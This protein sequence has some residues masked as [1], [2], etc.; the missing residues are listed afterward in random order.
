LLLSYTSLL[1]SNLSV[2]IE[3]FEEIIF[4]VG[5]LSEFLFIP[6]YSHSK[7]EE[8]QLFHHSLSILFLWCQNCTLWYHV[9]F[10]SKSD[11][12]SFKSCL[13]AFEYIKS[14]LGWN[15]IESIGS[16]DLDESWSKFVTRH[17]EFAVLRRYYVTV[18]NTIPLDATAA[19]HD[20]N[21]LIS[22]DTP[23]VSELFIFGN[24]NA[25]KHKE[26]RTRHL[27]IKNLRHLIK[28]TDLVLEWI[29]SD[30]QARSGFSNDD[31]F[32]IA[33]CKVSYFCLLADMK[34]T[35]EVE[36]QRQ[37]KVDSTIHHA[38]SQFRKVYEFVSHVCD[39]PDLEL[40]PWF[41][42]F[43]DRWLEDQKTEFCESRVQ[44][45]VEL[46]QDEPTGKCTTSVVDIFKLLY[47]MRNIFTLAAYSEAQALKFA[48]V[49]SQIIIFY[50]SKLMEDIRK[51]LPTRSRKASQEDAFTDAP[52]AEI[53]AYL[54]SQ[55]VPRLLSYLNN[56]VK[57]H[58]LL[59]KMLA[60][61]D[62]PSVYHSKPVLRDQVV[63]EADTTVSEVAPV[64]ILSDSDE[65]ESKILDQLNCVPCLLHIETSVQE[66][67][68][69]VFAGVIFVLSVI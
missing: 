32:V 14:F 9:A 69:N 6:E 63:N 50:I 22:T 56:I 20:L 59:V 53:M 67:I 41:S 49:I 17:I 65:E 54:E 1:A 25:S 37:V 16:I 12:G 58:E 51:L 57:C 7:K 24:W 18:K 4:L 46:D 21:S 45:A 47:D 31:T 61:I 36:N 52:E 13:T 29:T 66:I 30:V 33:V 55:F 42:P 64:R 62:L 38:Y 23:K 60:D 43:V 28:V 19:V 26:L 5:K 8:L 48:S 44:K 10:P 40:Q 3:F 27:N 35:L 15:Y 34:K 11:D 39:I 68:H 2:S